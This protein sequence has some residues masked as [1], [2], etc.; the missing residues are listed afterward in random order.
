MTQN[1]MAANMWG[2]SFDT[3]NLPEWSQPLMAE[4]VLY[5]RSFL[6]ANPEVMKEDG[7]IDLSNG[8]SKL[9]IPEDISNVLSNA[10]AGAGAGASSAP[11]SS[12]APATSAAA[13]VPSEST[14]AAAASNAPNGALTTSPKFVVAL[15]A[16][17]AS[18][19]L[20]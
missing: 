5:A 6:A 10:N 17:A 12:A 20:L 16:A 14:S 18:F 11:G 3:A 2:G 8:G 15:A 13:S 7:T 19:F 9:M 4:N 1:N